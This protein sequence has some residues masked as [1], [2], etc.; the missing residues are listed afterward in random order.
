MC[1]DA[2]GASATVIPGCNPE[3]ACVVEATAPLHMASRIVVDGRGM[4]SP[5]WYPDVWLEED[6]N[7]AGA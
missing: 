2:W 3:L 4:P 5:R 1:H 7:E 6:H